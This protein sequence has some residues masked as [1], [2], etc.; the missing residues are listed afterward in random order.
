[1]S[2]REQG[3]ACTCGIV[4]AELLQG[5]RSEK[6]SDLAL[7][8]SETTKV[9]EDSLGAWEEAGRLAALMRRKGQALSL[10]DCYLAALAV[11]NGAAILSLDKHFTI[12]SRQFPLELHS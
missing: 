3:R 6:D 5:S 11:E 12:I 1:M 8:L 7:S 9:L 4:I 2:L 10:V